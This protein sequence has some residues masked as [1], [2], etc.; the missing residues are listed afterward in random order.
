MIRYIAVALV[1]IGGAILTHPPAAAARCYGSGASFRCD[2]II[3][4]SLRRK[5]L[6][7]P[8]RYAPRS[9]RP[10]SYKGRTYS[11]PSGMTM[12]RYKYKSPNGRTYKGKIETFP[13]GAVRDTGDAGSKARKRGM[14]WNKK[15]Q[16]ILRM[17][18]SL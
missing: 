5:S 2:P 1:F 7:L 9:S 11:T 3:S 8:N 16:R 12:H 10:Y 13:G 4:D 18:D 17:A 15:N 6:G 14:V